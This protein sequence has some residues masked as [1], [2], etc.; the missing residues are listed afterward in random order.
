MLYFYDLGKSGTF[1]IPNQILRDSMTELFKIHKNGSVPGRRD[2]W[3]SCARLFR[4]GNVCPYSV[5]TGHV[6][7]C[8]NLDMLVSGFRFLGSCIVSKL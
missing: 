6:C 2:G 1:G 5:L 3:D 4:G 8:S 7:L